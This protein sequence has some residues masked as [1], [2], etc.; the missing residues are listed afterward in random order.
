M[1]V[2]LEIITFRFSATGVWG[3]EFYRTD[4]RRQVGSVSGMVLPS[5][6]ARI[7]SENVHLYSSF[8]LDTTIITRGSFTRTRPES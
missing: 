2:P 1:P 5:A 6:Q 4:C 8:D 7:D 3:Y